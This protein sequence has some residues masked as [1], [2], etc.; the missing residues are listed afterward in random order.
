V[1]TKLDTDPEVLARAQRTMDRIAVTVR[2]LYRRHGMEPLT[3][4]S[5]EDQKPNHQASNGATKSVGK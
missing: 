4:P 5:D 1:N 3:W 2:E